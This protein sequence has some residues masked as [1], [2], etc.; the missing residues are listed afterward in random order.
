MIILYLVVKNE[1]KYLDEYIQ[2]NLG[3]GIDR[4]L[5]LDDQ[6]TDNTK[7]IVQ[8]YIDMD[9]VDYFYD[10]TITPVAGLHRQKYR[11]IYIQKY[12]DFCFLYLDIDE[13]LFVKGMDIANFMDS[14]EFKNNE[15]FNLQESVCFREKPEP[16]L[17]LWNNHT[18]NLHTLKLSRCS[19]A[20]L[21]IYKHKNP[22]WIDGHR[23]CYN[24]SKAYNRCNF[25]I[26]FWHMKPSEEEMLEKQKYYDKS[27][28]NPY[29]KNAE[30]VR[31]KSR[32]RS[33]L[34]IGKNFTVKIYSSVV[35]QKF[36]QKYNFFMVRKIFPHHPTLKDICENNMIRNVITNFG[37]TI[38]NIKPSELNKA[39]PNSILSIM[40]PE[41]IAI[42]NFNLY[43]GDVLFISPT[44]KMNKTPQSCLV[45]EYVDFSDMGLVDNLFDA[46][47]Y[48]RIKAQ[49]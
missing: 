41:K 24:R 35:F 15:N 17:T 47:E 21:K 22:I 32:E 2:Y 31:K 48:R 27:K 1:A 5:I 33:R 11:N 4:L 19:K 40:S 3:S 39:K 13:F 20:L 25:N 43:P 14:D 10:T 23:C 18:W 34:R 16:G 37:L 42:N 30:Q 38:A 44:F 9:K 26:G 28:S 7:E 46:V 49:K 8:P 36:Y 29:Y 45:I 12:E 6:S